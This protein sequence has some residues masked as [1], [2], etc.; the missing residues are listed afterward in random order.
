LRKLTVFAAS[1]LA[2]SA[3]AQTYPSPTFNNLTVTGTATLPAGTA[4]SNGATPH[5]VNTPAVQ[6]ITNTT[7]YPAIIRDNYATSGDGGTAWY[8]LTVGGTCANADNGAQIQSVAGCYVADFSKFSATPNIWGAP[9]GSASTTQFTAIMAA[10][11]TA[12]GTL[13]IPA[14]LNYTAFVSVPADVR[15]ECDGDSA[16]GFVAPSINGTPV[17][18]LNGN[19][20]GIYHCLVNGG[21]LAP[22][23]RRSDGILINAGVQFAEAKYNEVIATSDNGIEDAGINTDIDAN[24]VHDVFTNCYYSFGTPGQFAQDGNWH[25]NVARACSKIVPFVGQGYISGTTLTILSV[26]SGQVAVGIS[27]ITQDVVTGAGV[28]GST[29]LTSVG[30]GTGGVGTYTVNN[31]Q[32]VGSAGSPVAITITY[33]RL[34]DGFDLDPCHSGFKLYNNRAYGND[35]IIAGAYSAPSATCG[36][37]FGDQINENWSYSS[38]ENGIALLGQL[39]DEQ[40][41]GNHVMTPTGW[42]IY[43]NTAGYAQSRIALNHNT[44][45]GSTKDGI[46]LANFLSGVTGGPVDWDISN[47]HVENVGATFS[48]ITI[49]SGATLI[50]GTG[51]VIIPG[52]GAYAID[53]SAAGVGVAFTGG[54]LTAGGTGIVN[55]TTSA[56]QAFEYIPGFN[57]TGYLSGAPSIPATTVAQTNTYPFPVSICITGGAVSALAVGGTT[58]GLTIGCL[59]V[60]PGQTWTPS[61]TVAPTVKWFGL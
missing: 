56:Q 41:N 32:T 33:P 48:G 36:L 35:F 46:Y 20:A 15:I 37:A 4:V 40:V 8:N 6:A 38:V 28:A 54:S 60:G 24:Y 10:L 17:V 49:S 18:T 13:H 59:T 5:F 7:L 34:W 25:N 61:Y 29:N 21:A 11:G 26:T 1:L 19:H 45:V 9:T 58:T 31:S 12:G 23:T 22:F 42:G 53:S 47:N 39:R 27:P 43:T 3:M 55:Y 52:S 14:G 2:S 30:T 57:P 44:V 16:S 50:Y 51:N